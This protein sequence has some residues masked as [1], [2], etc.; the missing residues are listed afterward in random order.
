MNHSSL[1]YAADQPHG[2]TTPSRKRTEGLA[3]IW[4]LAFSLRVSLL[5]CSSLSAHFHPSI[6][7]LFNWLSVK[8]PL[9]ASTCPCHSKQRQLGDTAL[10]LFFPM[11]ACYSSLTSSLTFFYFVCF[12]SPLLPCLFGITSFSPHAFFFSQ[13]FFFFVPVSF[14]LTCIHFLASVRIP[15]HHNKLKSSLSLFSICSYWAQWI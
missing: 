7:S 14:C 12:W 3:A 1:I 8:V 10:S 5:L 6:S 15:W 13:T 11:S 9:S 2:A 4:G